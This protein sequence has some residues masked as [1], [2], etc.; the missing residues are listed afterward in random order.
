MDFPD[1]DHI[2]PLRPGFPSA[3]HATQR[4]AWFCARSASR[5]VA[6]RMRRALECLSRRLFRAGGRHRREYHSYVPAGRR[7]IADA[8]KRPGRGRGSSSWRR[9]QRSSG[10]AH[11]PGS[12]CPVAMG[13]RTCAIDS[14]VLADIVVM[15]LLYV[16]VALKSVRAPG[17]RRRHSLS[18]TIGEVLP[19]TSRAGSRSLPALSLVSAKHR[20]VVRAGPDA[21]KR[22]VCRGTRGLAGIRCL[23][24]SVRGRPLVGGLAVG[25][26]CGEPGFSVSAGRSPHAR[27]RLYR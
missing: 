6:R 13:T 1:R 12:T 9:S 21:W 15:A 26:T 18:S 3:V 25:R 16:F 24:G 23:F 5:S 27:L 10:T 22:L 7:G 2:R 4:H 19:R 17:T 8:G 11:L 14:L 20:S